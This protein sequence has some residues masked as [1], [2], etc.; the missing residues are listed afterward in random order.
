[1]FLGHFGLGLAAKKINSRPSLGTF[2]LA[3]QFLDLLWPALLLRG[4]ERVAI[5][6]G[7]T[8]FTPLNFVYYPYSHSLA[9]AIFW[10]IVFG[11]IYFLFTRDRR[12]TLLMAILVFSH[13]VLD[14]ITHRPDLPLSPWSDKKFGLGLW[15]STIATIIVELII[16]IWGVYVYAKNTS[17]NGTAG[18]FALWSFV[19]FMLTVYFMNAFGPPPDSIDSIA[20][21]GLTQ[22]LLIAWGYWIDYTRVWNAAK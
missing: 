11:L 3:V 12:S 10:S 8:E 1:M 15:N 17:A 18:Q 6:P 7:N 19:A 20:I 5:E 9:G 14:F 21:L 22:W 16:F 2:F 13:W 4:V